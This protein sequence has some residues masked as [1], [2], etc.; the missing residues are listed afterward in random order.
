[1][2]KAK[3]TLT[4]LTSIAVVG[5]IAFLLL[6]PAALERD[7]PRDLPWVLPDYR[8]AHTQWEIGDDG[9]IYAEVE[10]FF[11][12]GISPAMVAWFYQQLPISTVELN[13][14][15]YPLYHIFHPVG[16]GRI[17]V[18]EGAADGSPGMAR[19]ATIMREEWFGPYDSRGTARLVEFSNDGMLAVPIAAGME[20][21]QVRHIYRAENGGTAY[22]V[23]AVIGSTLPVI[24]PIL[25]W[26][27]RTQVFHPAMMALWQQ[28]QIEEVASLQFFLA[29]L[30]AQRGGENHYV[31]N[32]PD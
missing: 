11:L 4:T 16:H 13:G 7:A 10:H 24:G 14:T 15:I 28:H 23:Q 32:I 22:K 19:G 31:L 3:R 29:D 25:N 6:S 21:G 30:Y 18:V 1:M 2:K 20:I 5:V 26:F 8:S 12:Q 9:R 27:I 17:R